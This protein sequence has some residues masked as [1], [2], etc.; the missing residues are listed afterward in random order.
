MSIVINFAYHCG[1]DR[2]GTQTTVF[3]IPFHYLTYHLPV[4]VARPNSLHTEEVRRRKPG[5]SH[6]PSCKFLAKESRVVYYIES[7]ILT[8][9]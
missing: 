3:H 2:S 4:V 7:G 9:P 1:H 8:Y 6:R 5:R